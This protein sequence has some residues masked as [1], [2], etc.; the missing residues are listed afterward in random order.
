MHFVLGDITKMD[1]DAIVNA[2]ASD[3]NP[4]TGFVVQFF[5]RRIPKN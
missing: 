4:V 2:A 3:L 1:T 5:V